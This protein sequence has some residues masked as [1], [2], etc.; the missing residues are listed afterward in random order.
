VGEYPYLD[1]K[2]RLRIF[3]SK[4]YN[5]MGYGL[6]KIVEN[7]HFQNKQHSWALIY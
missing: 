5:Y 2:V 3:I 7:N 6:I 1:F 4:D